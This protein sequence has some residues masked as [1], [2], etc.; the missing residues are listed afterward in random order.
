MLPQERLACFRPTAGQRL[1]GRQQLKCL[2]MFWGRDPNN[3]TP[4]PDNVDGSFYVD[5]TCI[6]EDRKELLLEER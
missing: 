2:A 3:R 6:G 5:H 1:A 4:R